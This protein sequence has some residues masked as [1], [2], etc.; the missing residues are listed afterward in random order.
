MFQD[1]KYTRNQHYD[2]ADTAAH[3]DKSP[4]TR[5]FPDKGSHIHLPH[6]SQR[7]TN[8]Y[9]LKFLSVNTL[10]NFIQKITH[11]ALPLANS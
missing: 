3:T 2:T 5:Y 9:L 4:H 11:E 1:H 8:N 6:N 10:Y 7:T